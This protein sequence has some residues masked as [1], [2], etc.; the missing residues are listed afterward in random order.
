[1]REG[2][3]AVC[4]EF[5]TPLTPTALDRGLSTTITPTTLRALAEYEI[6]RGGGEWS[7]E[8]GWARRRECK[9]RHRRV[10]VVWMVEERRREE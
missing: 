5:W 2:H 4:V 1:V 6:G 9:W 8:G 3:S 7:G 10:G